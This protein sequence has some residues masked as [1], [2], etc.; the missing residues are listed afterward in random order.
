LPELLSKG[1]FLEALH[2]VAQDGT[3]VREVTLSPAPE[4]IP[5]AIA[6]NGAR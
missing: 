3:R 1:G 2:A 5:A 4:P 6:S